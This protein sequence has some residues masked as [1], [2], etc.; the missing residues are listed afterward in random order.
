MCNGEKYI[1][2]GRYVRQIL[3]EFVYLTA[4]SAW[5]AEDNCNRLATCAFSHF[6]VKIKVTA[7]DVNL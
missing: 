3:S 6:E 1:E 4:L 5:F 2:Y 7:S